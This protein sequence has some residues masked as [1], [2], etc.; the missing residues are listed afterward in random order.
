MY[1]TL[2]VKMV[3]AFV[4]HARQ[5]EAKSEAI[6]D[7]A[8]ALL[9]R[10]GLEALTLARVAGEL[11]LA[12]GALYRYFD[13][14]DALLAALHRHA[15]ARTHAGLARALSD[16][17]ERL[18]RLREDTRALARIVHASRYYLSLPR[19]MG[20]A[21]AL[22]S[23][24]MADPR[25]LV[26]DGAAAASAEPIAALLCDAAALFQRAIDAGA[27]EPADALQH[28]AS[29][30]AALHGHTQLGKLR[31]LGPGFAASMADPSAERTVLTLLRGMGAEPGALR[32][33]VRAADRLCPEGSLGGAPQGEDR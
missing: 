3:H 31:R 21:F 29:L 17:D 11:G 33:A 2:F 9:A 15:I 27:L 26:D 30:W 12:T 14:K 6:V 10:E 22:L 24:M 28:T 32:R 20:D 19:T 1:F 7:A 16:A 18:P 23:L 25:P 4:P 8:M 13:G 5:R